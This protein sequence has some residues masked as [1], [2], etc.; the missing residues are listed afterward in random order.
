MALMESA[1][2]VSVIIRSMDRPELAE[3]MASVADQRYS[4]IEVVVVNAKG[5]DHQT[6]S[7]H[8]GPFPLRLVESPQNLPRAQAA[9]VGLDNAHG[10]YLL[11]LDDDDLLLTEHI[12]RLIIAL[13]EDASA[14]A[15]YA[16]VVLQDQAGKVLFYLDEPWQPERLRGANF[17]PIHAVLF[18]RQHPLSCRFN[19]ALSA[20]EDWDF[21]QQLSVQ[22]KF[23]HVPGISAIYRCELGLSEVSN[24]ADI[25]MLLENRTSIMAHWLQRYSPREWAETLHYY[26]M[27]MH[28]TRNLRCQVEALRVERE[29]LRV[30]REALVESGRLLQDLLQRGAWRML[31]P[32]RWLAR[33]TRPWRQRNRSV[34]PH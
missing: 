5:S 3:A 9:N 4:N 33:V 2:L 13:H 29:A 21:W 26:D 30:E 23:I 6:L 25:A 15:A 12:E 34:A 11:F 14:V 7:P 27:A 32:L 16:G 22:G 8:C 19:A 20:L 24:N 10:E 1:P 28:E 31:P 17:L 18:R